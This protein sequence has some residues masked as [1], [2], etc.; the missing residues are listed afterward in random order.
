LKASSQKFLQ[1]TASLNVDSVIMD[2][3]DGVAT[4]MKE[5][6]RKNLEWAVANLDFGKSEVLVSIMSTFY[7]IFYFVVFYLYFHYFFIVIVCNF[8]FYLY[9]IVIVIFNCYFFIVIFA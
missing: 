2:I 8:Y 5:E 6:A 4:N 9:F 3:E 1:K 7:F